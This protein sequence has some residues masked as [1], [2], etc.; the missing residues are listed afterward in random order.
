LFFFCL[1]HSHGRIKKEKGREWLPCWIIFSLK[2]E[3]EEEEEVWY[4]R[5]FHNWE[6]NFPDRKGNGDEEKRILLYKKRKWYSKVKRITRNGISTIL[7]LKERKQQQK[8]LIEN[9][10]R[11]KKKEKTSLFFFESFSFVCQ[12]A[13]VSPIKLSIYYKTRIS[14]LRWLVRERESQH[15]STEEILKVRV[16]YKWVFFFDCVMR[17]R[18]NDDNNQNWKFLKIKNIYI[19]KRVMDSLNNNMQ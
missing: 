17:N 5:L 10:I 19:K 8:I 9:K 16:L 15:S 13:C 7:Y 1:L 18:F 11:E 12:M 6:T 2:L 14:E 4:F 3:E